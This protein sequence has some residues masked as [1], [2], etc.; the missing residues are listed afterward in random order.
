MRNTVCSSDPSVQTDLFVC[1]FGEEACRPGHAF[2][3]HI[4]DHVLI[5]FVASGCGVFCCGGRTY[6]VGA[7]QGFLILPGEETRYQADAR[8]PW[9]YAWVGFRG[10][11]AEALARSAG[12]DAH[13]RVF[14]AAD[15]QKAWNALALMQE[16]ARDLRLLQMA[17]AGDLLR[18]LS[19]IAPERSLSAES[20]A[21]AYCE[22]ALWY[23][24]GRY[25]RDVSV[26]ETA[27]FVGVSR[28]HLYR[29]M[30]EVLGC[31]PKAKL[32]EIR[33]RHARQLLLT[34]S[35]T[36]E[37]VAHRIGLQT[38][39]QLGTVFRAY[40]GISPGAFRTQAAKDGRRSGGDAP[41]SPHS[42]TDKERP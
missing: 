10:S 40:H 13:H 3:P 31:S 41:R 42:P 14:T 24:E 36:L 35:L 33:M 9:H 29:L 28:S 38:G 23:L 32:L 16:D 2:G 34:T 12:L 20:P 26:Q 27:E 1:Q 5:H 25:D 6:P 21:Q 30:M 7:G 22:K 19:L 37:D 4:R 17:V 11:Q 39:T 15:P 8:T 18:F